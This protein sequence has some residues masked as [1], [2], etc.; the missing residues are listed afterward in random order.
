MRNL[1]FGR[2]IVLP[3]TIAI[4]HQV[5]ML[6]AI[7]VKKIAD[8]ARAEVFPGSPSVAGPAAIPNADINAKTDFNGRADFGHV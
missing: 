5:R 2:K 4:K 3:S 6:M 1:R 8:E 7:E